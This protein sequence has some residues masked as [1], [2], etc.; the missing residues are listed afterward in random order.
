MRVTTIQ[1]TLAVDSLQMQQAEAT[2][3]PVGCNLKERWC[4][5]IEPLAAAM[6]AQ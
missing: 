5:S 3:T 6:A 1:G 2:F 4:G